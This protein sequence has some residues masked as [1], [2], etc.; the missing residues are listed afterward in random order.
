[1]NP[2]FVALALAVLAPLVFTRPSSAALRRPGLQPT[3]ESR[4]VWADFDQDGLDDVF[5]VEADGRG[6]LL[7]NLG[8]GRF[9]DATAELALQGL[10]ASSARAC[11]FDRDGDPDLLV[12]L[13]DGGV[14]LF[15]SEGASLVA[16][17][18]LEGLPL[19]LDVTRA[20]WI[21]LDGNDRP[22]LE[23]LRSDGSLVLARNL[24]GR[25]FERVELGLRAGAPVA[26]VPA[27]SGVPP[28]GPAEDRGNSSEPGRSPVP[29]SASSPGNDS[30]SREFARSGDLPSDV[31]FAGG[32]GGSAGAIA[33]PVCALALEDQDGSGC[34]RANSEPTLGMLYPLSNDLFIEAATGEVGVGT[35]NPTAR[36][37]VNGA[38]RFAD[39]VTLQ[40]DLDSIRFSPA[41]GS[42]AA[43][44]EMFASGTTNADRMVLGHSPT[45][46][47]W[48][49]EYED[50]SDSFVFQRGDF[51]GSP[52][53]VMSV[54]LGSGDVTVHDGFLRVTSA[55][56]YGALWAT[57]TSTTGGVGLLAQNASLYGGAAI[58]EQTTAIGTQNN[59]VVIEAL[60]G[61]SPTAQFLQCQDSNASVKF[62]VDV[63]GA[64]YS[65]VG[66]S[67][68]ADLAEMIEVTSGAESVEPG[69]VL[70]IDAGS[71]RGVR[72]S[73]SARSTLVAGVYST[74]PG[75][76]GSEREW[77]VDA[78]PG[79]SEAARGE[80]IALE[81]A[82]MARLYDEVPMAVVG[83]VPCKVSAEN[84]PI[85]PGDLL[86]TSSVPGHA[87]RDADPRNGTIVG[88][89]L[90]PL[91][92]G[93]GTIRV[94]VT[95]Q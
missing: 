68:G 54:G 19:E 13:R 28:T 60:I 53:R 22:D 88:K 6:V 50:G 41:S 21:E 25:S 62:R 76:V 95:L 90:E 64:A 36:L 73:T 52:Y 8:Q 16:S 91:G 29:G 37:D 7:R 32:V 86:V 93:T 9:A 83:I 89:A 14:R 15:D 77:D 63:D 34:L 47:S 33:I 3:G 74:A 2:S 66:F 94:L 5:L 10:R 42:S 61:T 48:G 12:V 87:M 11:D 59:V 35:T 71:S 79:S 24:D 78:A 30:T 72:R 67:T 57:N 70:V 56:A 84:G 40:D 44:I 39:D 20:E 49:L 51:F 81:R 82:D 45:Y 85:R 1:M 69:D 65:D 38:A 92:A 4:P 58:I 46:P 17:S 27:A 31:A 23:L 26:A 18:A 75:F 43:M 55:D 80:R